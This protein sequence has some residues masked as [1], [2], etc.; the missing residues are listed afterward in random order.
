MASDIQLPAAQA[1][2]AEA[3]VQAKPRRE[4]MAELAKAIPFIGPVAATDIK[5]GSHR[6]PAARRPPRL[7]NGRVPARPAAAGRGHAGADGT[8]RLGALAGRGLSQ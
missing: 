1:S 2:A 8:T 5:N 3:G 4:V 7:L 6:V